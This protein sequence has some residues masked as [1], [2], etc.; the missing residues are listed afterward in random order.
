MSNFY[1]PLESLDVVSKAEAS[2]L[3][4]DSNGLESSSKAMKNDRHGIC[5]KCQNAMTEAYC[6][7][8]QVYHCAGCRV[9]SPMLVE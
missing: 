3:E 5:A 9:T 7:S 8:E 2:A 6:G 1:N 4:S